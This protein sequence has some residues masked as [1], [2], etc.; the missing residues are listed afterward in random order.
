M[1]VPEFSSTIVTHGYSGK[2]QIP[3]WGIVENKVCLIF[4]LKS[5]EVWEKSMWRRE[6][7]CREYLV[8][9]VLKALDSGAGRAF[10][11]RWAMCCTDPV[12]VTLY[13]QVGVGETVWES[14]CPLIC[15][16]LCHPWYQ[17]S[18]LGREGGRMSVNI[19]WWS[20]TN[21]VCERHLKV[22]QPCVISLL[23]SV[24]TLFSMVQ[25]SCTEIVLFLQHHWSG[26][27]R[28]DVLFRQRFS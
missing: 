25:N 15:G 1:F 16:C 19:L 3:E 24:A 12:T 6:I 10:D 4:F 8:M 14:S 2:T 18:G 11:C 5:V 21:C 22:L 20:W 17:R 23:C 9:Q 7:T 26:H 13:L 27:V 28:S